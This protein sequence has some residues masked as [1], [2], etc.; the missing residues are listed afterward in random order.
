MEPY[1]SGLA[2]ADCWGSDGARSPFMQYE[3]AI[4]VIHMTDGVICCN[5]AVN[6]QTHCQNDSSDD[7]INYS[8][9]RKLLLRFYDIYTNK[10]V[11]VLSY[12]YSTQHE[13]C[14]RNITA[15]W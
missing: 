12:D 15:S 11:T 13:R 10:N 9:M 2:G 5:F 3:Y 8:D 7:R 4:L 1:R 6:C 14:R